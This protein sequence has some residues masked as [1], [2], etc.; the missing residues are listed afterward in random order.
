MVHTCHSLIVLISCRGYPEVLGIPLSD[1]RPQ[2]LLYLLGCTILHQKQ[3]ARALRNPGLEYQYIYAV[4][5][6]LLDSRHRCDS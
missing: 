2:I 4:R 1:E 5:G 6:L 3:A